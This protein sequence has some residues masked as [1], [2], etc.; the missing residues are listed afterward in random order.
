MK[1]RENSP[2]LKDS[3]WLLVL[4]MLALPVSAN[5]VRIFTLSADEWA[6]PRN[7]EVIPQMTETLIKEEIRRGKD[8]PDREM[9][10]RLAGSNFKNHPYGRPVIG[11]PETVDKTDRE[12]L[13]RIFKQWYVPNNMVFVAAGDF[14]RD[15]L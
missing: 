5:T 6:R 9:W 11:Y 13:L 8:S 12:A 7:G 15:P 3:L 14:D 1:I 10:Y 2:K 4:L